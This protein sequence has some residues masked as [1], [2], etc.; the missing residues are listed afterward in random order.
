MSIVQPF[1]NENKNRNLMWGGRMDN[2]E[3]QKKCFSSQKQ[4]RDWCREYEAISIMYLA[5]PKCRE[6]CPYTKKCKE[7]WER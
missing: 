1:K 5:Q 6:F 4:H 7:I 3:A 2:N